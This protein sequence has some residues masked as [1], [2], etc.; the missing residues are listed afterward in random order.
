MDWRRARKTEDQQGKL[1]TSKE[2]WKQARKTEDDQGKLKT[3]KES[4]RLLWRET[5]HWVLKEHGGYTGGGWHTSHWYWATPKIGMTF[6]DNGTKNGHSTLE[7][8]LQFSDGRETQFCQCLY[9]NL[10]TILSLTK[11][12]YRMKCSYT[13]LKVIN[14]PCLVHL[15]FKMLWYCVRCQPKFVIWSGGSQSFLQIILDIFYIYE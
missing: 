15:L 12:K 9:R 11:I 14:A 5:L 1:K 2:N 6:L 10:R 7:W 3:N 13:S 8:I 4:W